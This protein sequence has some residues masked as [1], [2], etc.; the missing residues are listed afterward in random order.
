MRT[1][2]L[3]QVITANRGTAFLPH[4]NFG[5]DLAFCLRC[6][7]L[8]IKMYGEPGVICGHIGHEAIYP[9]DAQRYK[10]SLSKN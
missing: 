2:I 7:R 4:A 8:G 1:E 9:E 10:D 5:E 3:Q 6:K